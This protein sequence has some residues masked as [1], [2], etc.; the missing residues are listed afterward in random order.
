LLAVGSFPDHV[1]FEEGMRVNRLIS[2]VLMHE[3]LF[4]RVRESEQEEAATGWTRDRA[5]IQAAT[6]ASGL[7]SYDVGRDGEQIGQFSL[8][9]GKGGDVVSD[10]S[11][12]KGSESAEALMNQ[13][14]KV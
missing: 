11:W 14:V 4:L 8:A 2:A 7:T 12:S 3:D 5:E 1:V 6:G 10:W 9:F 13:L